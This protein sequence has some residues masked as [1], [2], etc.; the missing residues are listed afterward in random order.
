M[1]IHPLWGQLIGVLTLDATQTLAALT[2]H[3]VRWTQESPDA[4]A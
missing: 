4:V 2:P 1:S 3:A